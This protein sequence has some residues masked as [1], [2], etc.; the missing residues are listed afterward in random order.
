MGNIRRGCGE[1]I[2]RKKKKNGC[3]FGFNPTYLNDPNSK[4]NC[5]EDCH[6][7]VGFSSPKEVNEHQL[8]PKCPM[9]RLMAVKFK[10]CFEEM[11]RMKPRKRK[12]EL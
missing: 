3:I 6:L 4:T 9:E 5:K 8:E 12:R 1:I 2:K 10:D 11:N 7:R